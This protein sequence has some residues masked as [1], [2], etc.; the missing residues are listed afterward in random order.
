MNTQTS[1]LISL[2]GR[3]TIANRRRE[4]F[5]RSVGE[6][7]EATER[8]TSAGR[9]PDTVSSL[10]ASVAVLRAAM[11]P[12]ELERL[13]VDAEL[14]VERLSPGSHFRSAALHVL[15]VVHLLADNEGPDA[16]APQAKRRTDDKDPELIRFRGRLA[17]TLTPAELRL[18]P[19]LA[20][21][22]SFSGIGERLYITRNTVKTEAISAYRKLGASSRSE[23]VERATELGLIKATAATVVGDVGSL[24]ARTEEQ[25]SQLTLALVAW[26]TAGLHLL[27][28]AST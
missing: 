8:P 5:R 19:F 1:T 25:L 23:A 15:E 4:T 22:L 21:H 27:A 17:D 2:E 6:F 12:E 16:P 14:A 20:T 24:P 3:G 13:R 26:S 18:L 11:R 7:L 9:L 10:E 28:P